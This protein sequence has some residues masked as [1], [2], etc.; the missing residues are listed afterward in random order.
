MS[1]IIIGLTSESKPEVQQWGEKK[2]VPLNVKEVR[3]ADEE[4]NEKV[5]YVYDVIER[6][7]TPVCIDTIVSAGVKAKF[8]DDEMGYIMKHFAK[9]SDPKVAEYKEFVT[10][11]TA[12]AESAGY[13]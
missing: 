12:D 11:L 10:R 7:E 2:H 3:E 8:S 5:K 13:E 6:V 1:K 4:G 9:E